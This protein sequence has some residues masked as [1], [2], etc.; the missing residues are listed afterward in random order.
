MAALEGILLKHDYQLG[1]AA[2]EAYLYA[3]AMMA[4]RA[5]REQPPIMRAVPAD[6]SFPDGPMVGNIATVP[7]WA[8]DELNR[9]RE[10][11]NEKQKKI[12][13]YTR[14]RSAI[15]QQLNEQTELAE[16]LAHELS[17]H[18]PHTDKL[19]DL[20]AYCVANNIGQIGQDA[21][22]AI[23]A[24]CDARAKRIASLLTD[25]NMLQ[26]ALAGLMQFTSI[27]PELD[28]AKSVMDYMARQDD[29]GGL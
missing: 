28:K 26:T 22:K 24:E 16:Q 14:H 23:M 18:Q 8:H 5:K 2:Q 27:K 4:E 9:L 7:Q 21:H 13:E 25:R 17:M 29:E 12:D 6:P 11:I 10:K 3:E 1:E 15:Q 19:A 20:A